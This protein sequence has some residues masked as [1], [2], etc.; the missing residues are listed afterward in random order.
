MAEAG[1][2]ALRQ[3][4]AAIAP[5]QLLLPRFGA[6]LKDA[7]GGDA[8]GVLNAE[9]LA[10]LVEERQSKSGVAAQLDL[11]PGEGG[12]QTRQDSQQHGHDTGVAGGISRSQPRCQQTSGVALIQSVIWWMVRKGMLGSAKT[13]CSCTFYGFSIGT[14]SSDWL[15]FVL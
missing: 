4:R 2:A 5:L 7:V 10:E 11:H 13:Q 9:E 12:L 6:V 15:S 8:E 1:E 3:L 14:R